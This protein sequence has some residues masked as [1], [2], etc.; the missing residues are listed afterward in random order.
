MALVTK[1]VGV[2]FEQNGHCLLRHLSQVW[3]LWG[4]QAK[5]GYS[6]KEEQAHSPGK[7]G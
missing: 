2:H 1:G 7:K 4:L 5:E 3:L 6:Y